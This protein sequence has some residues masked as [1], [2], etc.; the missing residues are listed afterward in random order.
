VMDVLSLKDQDFSLRVGDTVV[1]P[2]LM[3]TELPSEPRTVA[4]PLAKNADVT[5]SADDRWG[6]GGKLVSTLE[7]VFGLDGRRQSCSGTATYTSAKG[8]Q[9]QFAPSGRAIS[10]NWPEG[11]TAKIGSDRWEASGDFLP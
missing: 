3:I 11:A 2:L 9:V 8:M 4:Y 5:P 10:I 1:H 6:G 7:P